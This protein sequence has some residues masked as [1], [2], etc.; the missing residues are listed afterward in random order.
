[1]DKAAARYLQG[2]FRPGRVLGRHRRLGNK[3]GGRAA[4]MSYF[5]GLWFSGSLLASSS[6]SLRPP[7]LCLSQW[8]LITPNS[9]HGASTVAAL[10]TWTCDQG[11]EVGASQAPLHWV[12]ASW[13]SLL[14]EWGSALLQG[15]SVAPRAMPL[16]GAGPSGASRPGTGLSLGTACDSHFQLSMKVCVF[17]PFPPMETIH[18]AMDLLL[19]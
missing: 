11:T 15:L 19:H 5:W 1:M 14:A 16:R 4:S 17:H 13:Q 10:L 18:H 8:V 9:C 7:S 3:E 6:L 12:P 2:S